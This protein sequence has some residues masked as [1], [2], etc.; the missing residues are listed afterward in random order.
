ME[1]N[2]SPPSCLR[3][4]AHLHF[5]ILIL[6]LYLYMYMHIHL[7]VGIYYISTSMYSY[8]PAL[9]KIWKL[10]LNQYTLLFNTVFFAVQIVPIYNTAF[11]IFLRA[12]L[13]VFIFHL[14]ELRISWVES[15]RWVAVFSSTTDATYC[16]G[17]LY[18]TYL[19]TFVVPLTRMSMPVPWLHR[20]HCKAIIPQIITSI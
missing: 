14:L 10:T 3:E 17:T 7:H 11:S 13:A 2:V 8:N 19:W 9:Q 15:N 20:V 18:S 16:W 5:Y 6:Y 12:S 1:E 4:W